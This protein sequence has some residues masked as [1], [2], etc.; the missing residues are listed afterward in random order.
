MKELETRID[1]FIREDSSIE[2]VEGSD[3]V[4]D[5]GAFAWS[6]LDP[7]EVNKQN[8]IHDEYIDLSNKVREILNNEN[9]PHKERFEQS[10][11]LVVSY[12]RQDT[13]LWVPG[14]VNVIN[15][16]KVQLNLQKFFI[17]DI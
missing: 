17:N 3:E 8:L 13:L 14:L 9:S 6:K 2:Y 7:S 11:E 12:I 5:G 4:V 15:D 1:E 10:Y 16:I